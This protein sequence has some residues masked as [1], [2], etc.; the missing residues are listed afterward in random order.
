MLW[1]Y[2]KRYTLIHW[3]KL[4]VIFLQVECFV[5]HGFSSLFDSAHFSFF[6]A[7]KTTR[8]CANYGQQTK[9]TEKDVCAYK[10]CLLCCWKKSIFSRLGRHITC[11]F[12]TSIFPAAIR[13]LCNGDLFLYGTSMCVYVCMRI[14]VRTIEPKIVKNKKR[15]RWKSDIYR[16]VRINIPSVKFRLAVARNS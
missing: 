10:V 9:A 13:L 8:L 4:K 6:F 2:C 14:C 5:N 3:G 12:S 16:E 1:N 11:L 15:K 7:I